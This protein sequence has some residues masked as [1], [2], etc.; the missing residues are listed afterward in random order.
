MNDLS[1]HDVDLDI[2][3]LLKLDID[4]LITKLWKKVNID[5]RLSLTLL[6]AKKIT[7]SASDINL[8]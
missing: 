3:I 5:L 2:K 1:E 7:K 4:P 8:V 6:F